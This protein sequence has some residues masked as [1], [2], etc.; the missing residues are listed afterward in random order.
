MTLD[1]P[2]GRDFGGISVVPFGNTIGARIIGLSLKDQI[3]TKVISVLRRAISEYC[4]I[5]IPEQDIEPSQLVAF[6]N[7]LGELT[8]YHREELRH[9]QHPEIVVLTNRGRDGTLRPDNSGGTQWWH[10]DGI[11]QDH[12]YAATLLQMIQKPSDTGNTEFVDM[13]A[14]YEALVESLKAQVDGY[15]AE[16]WMNGGLERATDTMVPN[17]QRAIHPIVRT[18]TSM[19]VRPT[20]YKYVSCQGAQVTTCYERCM[21]L[22]NGQSSDS[23]MI[24]GRR[25]L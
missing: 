10:F 20:Q 16:H 19:S 23:S 25:M 24:G 3:D 2:S 9:Q 14:V 5:A 7:S 22:Q 18:E 6:A 4:L 13:R 17:W 15:A 11:W 1:F 21:P 8:I 12:A